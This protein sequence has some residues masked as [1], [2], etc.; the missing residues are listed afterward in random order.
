VIMLRAMVEEA[1]VATPE[2]LV[3][4]GGE[5]GLD[6]HLQGIV[7]YWQAYARMITKIMPE[8]VDKNIY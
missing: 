7:T 8:A 6:N 1:E 3:G 5:V 4:G 2:E